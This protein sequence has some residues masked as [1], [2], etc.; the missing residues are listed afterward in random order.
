MNKFPTLKTID[1]WLRYPKS[2]RK[3]WGEGKNGIDWGSW[4]RIENLLLILK[5]KPNDNKFAIY[6]PRVWCPTDCYI[7][8]LN[9][10]NLTCFEKESLSCIDHEYEDWC[11]ECPRGYFVPK[12]LF[13]ELF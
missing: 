10:N 12:I 2:L 13:N 3:R 4:I 8:C 9:Y 6:N 1:E 5:R 7:L 11:L